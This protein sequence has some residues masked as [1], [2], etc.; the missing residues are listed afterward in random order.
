MRACLGSDK[1]FPIDLTIIAS[2]HSQIRNKAPM[3][4]SRHYKYSP[5]YE[6][7]IITTVFVVFVN[8]KEDFD[9]D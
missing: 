7:P 8:A 5:T 3:S 9:I 6:N 2:L 1:V 4:V